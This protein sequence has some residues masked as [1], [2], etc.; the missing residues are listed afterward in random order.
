[1]R[2]VYV[3]FFAKGQFKIVVCGAT[4]LQTPMI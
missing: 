2:R 1:M 3:Q 4:L